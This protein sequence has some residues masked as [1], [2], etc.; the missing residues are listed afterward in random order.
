VLI[1]ESGRLKNIGVACG[2]PAVAN[3]PGQPFMPAE[4]SP[5][6]GSMDG[7]MDKKYLIF[8]ATGVGLGHLMG[9]ILGSA[10]YAFHTGR[11]FAMDMRE[12]IFF[13]SD[14]H[15][16]FFENFEVQV[17]LGLEVITDLEQIEA[18][19]REPD[20]H[21]LSIAT[22]LDLGRPFPHK[23]VMVPCITPGD[24]FRPVVRRPDQVFRINLKAQ[25]AEALARAMALPYWSRRVIGL[26]YRATVGEL[27]E[28]M[29]KLTVPDYDERYQ[30]VKDNYVATAMKLVEGLDPDSYAFLVASDDRQFVA[31]LKQRLPNAF[32]IG[33]LRLD[34]E[35][36]AYMKANK[37]NLAILVDAVTDLW[38]LSR[39]EQL[40]YSR[41]AFTH[42]AI[43]N[44][45]TLGEGSTHYIHMPLFDEILL[46]LPPET[47]VEWARAAARKIEVSRMLYDKM[48]RYLADALQRAGKP[49][50][51]A[52]A[53]QQADWHDQAAHSP[54]VNNPDTF[55]ERAQQRAGKQDLALARARRVVARMPGNPYVHGGF[56]GSLS[57]LLM[58]HGQSAEAVEAARRAVE[59]DPRDAF[60]RDHLGTVLG[61]A[62][63]YEEAEKAFGEAISMVPDVPSLHV[64][65]GDSLAH[66]KR[67]PEALASMQRAIALDPENARTHTV[68]G[69]IFLRVEN[70][71]RA[72]EAFRK[73]VSLNKT[74]FGLQ[75]RLSI[76]L[77]RQKRYD[78]ALVYAQAVL[79][80]DPENPDFRRRVANLLGICDDRV[81]A[82]AA[83]RAALSATPNDAVLHGALIENLKAQ[84]RQEDMMQAF[85]EAMLA[86]PGDA[87]F[88]SRYG[89]VL[90]GALRYVEAETVL[91]RAVALNG[92]DVGTRHLLSITY[93]RQEKFDDAILE[94]VAASKIDPRNPHRA[95]RVL[96]L[97]RRFALAKAEA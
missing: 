65:R 74:D 55:A 85:R 79:A 92:N 94:A 36:M 75:H 56:G 32:S 66:L 9:A 31:E 18:L 54:E 30:V 26:H 53:R 97:A 77:E 59:L 25:L 88:P 16:A 64:N 93:E 3:R 89:A 11:V 68:L 35:F 10:Y 19:K 95:D 48:H 17:P 73:A 63:Q 70:Y 69:E 72:E 78:D 90:L 71:P 12:V 14:S 4:V 87:G 39:C 24:P 82:E 60:L 33:T 20:L 45:E 43:L 7:L 57:S 50:E 1:N 2:L 83:I 80:N 13:D 49:D 40:I 28:R 91:R 6:D 8:A 15:N 86:V 47:A 51:A 84:D 81:A 42:F 58:F 34:Q 38:A 62:G 44:S 76:A 52:Y 41:S 37:H 96:A 23:V 27:F 46:S 61:R 67:L 29:T 5:M 22:P 21:Y